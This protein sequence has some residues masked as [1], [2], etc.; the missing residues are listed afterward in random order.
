MSKR[1]KYRFKKQVFKQV[2]ENQ[3]TRKNAIAKK[4][5]RIEELE[6]VENYERKR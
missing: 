2:L 5:D 3:K 6:E 4:M 1:N